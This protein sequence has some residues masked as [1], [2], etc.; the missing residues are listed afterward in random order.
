A[1]AE[2]CRPVIVV[3]D[4][5]PAVLLP[6]E[7]LA[8]DIHVISDLR[9]AVEAATISAVLRWRAGEQGWRWTGDVPADSCVRV[10]TIQVVVPDAPGDFVL[11]LDLVAGD[12]AASNRYESVIVPRV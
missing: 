5:A 11:D 7:A 2:A 1:V 3:A 4:R 9:T 12:T 8:L 6:G 10:G